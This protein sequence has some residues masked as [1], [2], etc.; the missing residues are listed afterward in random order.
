MTAQV[1]RCDRRQFFDVRPHLFSTERTVDANRQKLCV[2]YRV[3]KGFDGLSRKGAAAVI[4][5]RDGNHDREP[6]PG[7]RKISLER[8]QSSLRVESVE[9]RLGEQHIDAAL[10]QPTCLF[11]VGS[12]ERVKG[13]G[14]KR[15][16]VDV[17]RHRR[18]AIRRS[19][20]PGYK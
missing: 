1:N 5:N 7:F 6:K 10:D 18:R 19:D 12:D 8:K 9:D 3:P 13:R 11:M 15:R 14:A 2:G 4:G 20:G 17:R 16:I